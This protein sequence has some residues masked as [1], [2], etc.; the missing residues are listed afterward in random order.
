MST[1]IHYVRHASYEN[2]GLLIPG[3]IPGYHLN[4]EGREK[5]RK[6]G[7]FFKNKP[8]K[9]IYSSPLE[10]AY[11]TANLIGEYLPEAKIIHAYDLIEIDA[12]NWQAYKVEELFT[13]NYYE[14]FMNNPDTSELPENLNKL[15]S[16]MKSFTF[17]L[18]KKHSEQEVI[19]VSHEFPILCHLKILGKSL[20]FHAS[21]DGLFHEHRIGQTHPDIHSEYLQ[22]SFSKILGLKGP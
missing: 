18:C 19:C 7:E 13:N 5:A 20:Q 8:I 14:D 2:P 11:E 10:R 4:D 9:F 1:I 6:T 17:T 21:C 22:K 3:R 16:R 15:A 12:A